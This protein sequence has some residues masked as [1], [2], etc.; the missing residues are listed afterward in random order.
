MMTPWQLNHAAFLTVLLTYAS[1]GLAYAQIRLKKVL[2]PQTLLAGGFF[3]AL[4]LVL[5]F[6]GKL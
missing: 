6:T 1:I 5:V 4:F 2:T 3:Y